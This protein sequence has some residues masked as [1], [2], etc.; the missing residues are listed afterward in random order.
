MTTDSIISLYHNG[1]IT[2]DCAAI[3]LLS[4]LNGENVAEVASSVPAEV[5]KGLLKHVSIDPSKPQIRIN[6]PPPPEP[7]N[8]AAVRH[9]LAQQQVTAK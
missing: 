6:A 1:A 9:W 4:L 7:H 2:A 3:Y 8:L 5:Y